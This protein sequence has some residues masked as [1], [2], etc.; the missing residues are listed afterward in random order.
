V[1]VS[2]S[3]PIYLTV[4][5]DTASVSQCHLPRTLC[6]GFV[7]R[8]CLRIN[9]PWNR[10]NVNSPISTVCI[11]WKQ[12]QLCYIAPMLYI[13]FYGSYILVY[14]FFL[15]SSWKWHRGSAV[16]IPLSIWK[17]EKMTVSVYLSSNYKLYVFDNRSMSSACGCLVK[18]YPGQLVLCQFVPNS[19]TKST[20]TQPSIWQ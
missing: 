14:C 16:F 9:V 20:R 19:G 18:S 5:P 11:D 10:Q 15:F 7:M 2:L 6:R 17:F 1:L 4:T 8:W 13:L 3:T 12:P